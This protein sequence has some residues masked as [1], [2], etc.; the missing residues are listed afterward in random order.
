MSDTVQEFLS[1]DQKNMVFENMSDGIITVNAEGNITYL[2]SACMEI[3]E[4]GEQEILNQSFRNI[5]IR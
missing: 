2:N 5:L 4:T 1:N 3:L